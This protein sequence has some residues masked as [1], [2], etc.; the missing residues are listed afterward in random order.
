MDQYSD[1]IAVTAS[2]A[3]L[4]YTYM[5]L[6]SAAKMTNGGKNPLCVISTLLYIDFVC[7]FT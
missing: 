1:V 7:G 5:M 2:W 3:L 6:G 4:S